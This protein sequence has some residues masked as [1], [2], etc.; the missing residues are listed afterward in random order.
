MSS[1]TAETTPSILERI[2]G[3]LEG[4]NTYGNSL[5]FWGGFTIVVAVLAVYP[6]TTDPYTIIQTSRYFALAFLALS[7]CFIWGYA[8]ILS[9]GQVAFFGVAAYAFGAIG[10]NL[11]SAMGVTTAIIGA[12]IVGTLVAALLGYFMFYGGVRDTYVTIMTLVVALVLNTFMAQTAGSEWAIG[13]AQLGGFN[14]MTNIP[15]LTLGIG[16]TGVVFDRA[17]F[18]Y[19]LL[20]ALVVIYLGLRMLVNSRFGLTMVA[21]REDETR[22]E[23]F[24][25]NVPFVKLAVFTVGGALAA[26]GGVFYASWGNYV[27]PSVFGIAFAALPVVWVSV[28]GRESLLGAIGATFV[29][30]RMRTELSSGIGP[31]GAEWALVIVGGLL[32]SV[33]LFMPAGVVPTVDALIDR[34]QARRTEQEQSPPPTE[35]AIE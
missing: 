11:S 13:D 29:I 25:Y 12:V 9:F 4:P 23:T 20:V 35:E 10:I 7:L 26:V 5:P 32:L 8:G 24:G 34:I 2:R 28:G 17:A 18:Y 33:I 1:D 19:A 16:Q 3:R 6:Q 21:I 22:T 27:D 31:I 30:E 14:G 15:N